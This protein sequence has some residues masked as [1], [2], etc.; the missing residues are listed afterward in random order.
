MGRWVG[1]PMGW[2]G[3][4]RLAPAPCP[5]R[6]LLSFSANHRK[7]RNRNDLQPSFE[8]P[9]LHSLLSALPDALMTHPHLAHPTHN[10]YACTCKHAHTYRHT[11]TQTRTRIHIQR[12]AHSHTN[13]HT[14]TLTHTLSLVGYVTAAALRGPVLLRRHPRPPATRRHRGRARLPR[15]DQRRRAQRSTSGDNAAQPLPEPA[16]AQAGGPWPAI[17][18]PAPRLLGEPRRDPVR[19]EGGREYV[20]AGGQEGAREGGRKG[21]R[22]GGWSGA[23]MMG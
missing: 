14:L 3:I 19:G 9:L 21:G 18:A 20:G 7:S 12:H 13:T 4:K 2:R 16:T 6:M 15:Q 5:H 17:Q 1:R 11:D 10:M 8:Q 23:C 22:E